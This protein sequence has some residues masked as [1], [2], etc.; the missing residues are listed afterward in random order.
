MNF[1]DGTLTVNGVGGMFDPGVADFT[2]DGLAPT[3]LPAL[4]IT[5]TA[6]ATL[7]GDLTVGSSKQ[8]KLTV[9]A[10]GVVSVAGS[11]TIGAQG[12]LILNA[13]TL[14]VAHTL[15]IEPGG[16]AT[17]NGSGSTFD[18]GGLTLQ[19]TGNLNFVGDPGLYVLGN[20][21]ANSALSLAG[22]L[23]V[24]PANLSLIDAD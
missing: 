22:T 6:S 1:H 11:A 13:G 17:V 2:I 20:A 7:S 14:D 4:V 15:T 5:N 19:E 12:N 23:G 10:G 16:T 9:E 21:A 8:G 18:F 24:G 3:D